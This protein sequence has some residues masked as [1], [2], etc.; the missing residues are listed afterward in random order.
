MA[1]NRIFQKKKK[2]KLH[3]EKTH[4]QNEINSTLILQD[5]ASSYIKLSPYPDSSVLWNYNKKSKK[6]ESVSILPH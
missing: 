1:F 4:T 2:K 3:K 6:S 5:T